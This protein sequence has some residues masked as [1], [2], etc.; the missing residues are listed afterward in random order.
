LE[1]PGG[2]GVRW[3]GGI[4]EGV[5]VGLFYDPL[6][7]KLIVHGA[8]REAALDRMSRALAELRV[9]GVETSAAFH[10]R[11]LQEPEFRSGDVT[12]RYLEEHA[13]IL[14]MSLDEETLRAAA[15]A[16]ALLE[17]GSRARRGTRRMGSETAA[18]SAW[19]EQGWR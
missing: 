16:A 2:P 8:D 13:D 1:T 11:V 15:V 3:D 18:R 12:I 7:G 14:T 4:V 6:L 10:R 9:V 19:R 17:D 5:E